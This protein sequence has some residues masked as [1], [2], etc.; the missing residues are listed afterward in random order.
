MLYYQ[1]SLPH[2]LQTR[3]DA[4]ISHEVRV[5]DLVVALAGDHR[6]SQDVA[7]NNTALVGGA[8]RWTDDDKE[9]TDI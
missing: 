1:D 9:T 7:E 4:R 8:P 5:G 6:R 3:P 2:A